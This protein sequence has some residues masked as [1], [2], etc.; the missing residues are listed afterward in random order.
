MMWVVLNVFKFTEYNNV[1]GTPSSLLSIS[2][3]RELDALKVFCITHDTLFS[4]KRNDF[5]TRYVV[6]ENN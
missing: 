4:T 1:N 2:S 3:V 5:G 6:L